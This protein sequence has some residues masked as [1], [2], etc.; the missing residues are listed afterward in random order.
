MKHL[1]LSLICTFG[2]LS[3]SAQSNVWRAVSESNIQLEQ[4]NK[5]SVRPSA[6][7]TFELDVNVLQT[8]LTQAPMEMTNEARSKAILVELPLADGR[9]ETFKIVNSPIAEPGYMAL[10]PEL[11][12]YS[13]ISVNHS[14]WTTRLVVTPSGFDA[15]ITTD[16][17]QVY[18]ET[19]AS[20]QTKYYIVYNTKD[21]DLTN[22][23][24][25]GPVTCGVHKQETIQDIIKEGQEVNSRGK[26]AEAVTIRKYRL[27]AATTGEFAALHGGTKAS[28]TAHLFKVMNKVN[29]VVGKEVAIRLSLIDK[30]DTL[31]FID[32]NKDPYPIGNQGGAMV[33]TNTG[34]LAKY[35]G[36][37]NYDFGHVFTGSCT[38]VGG[39]ASGLIC[40]QNG[41]GNG[42]SCDQ[43]SDAILLAVTIT[44]HE[45]G[46]Q[47]TAAHTMSDCEGV[48]PAQLG[49][50]IKIEPGSGTTIMSYDGG[51]GNQNLTG[52]YWKPNGYYHAG[53]LD[54]IISYT[55]TNVGNSCAQKLTSTTNMIP[56][57]NF[58]YKNGFNI[59]IS[60]PF[61][62][63]GTATDADNDVLTYAWDEFDRGV[64][65]SLGK[66]VTDAAI[67]R[68]Y[69]P[70]TDGNV[71][72]FPN[73]ASIV[74]NKKVV[75]ELLPTYDRK[76]TFRLIARDAKP[77]GGTAWKEVKFYA[78][79]TAGPFLVKFPNT[80]K[81]TL[82]ANKYTE[83]KWDVAKTNNTL[84]NCQKVSIALSTDGGYTYPTNLLL[85]T[86]NDGSEFVLIPDIASTKARVRVLAADN[87]FF[88][89]SNEDLQIVAATKPTYSLT[90]L[91][92]NPQVCLPGTANVNVNT[93][94]LAGFTKDVTFQVV[95]GLPNKAVATFTKNPL[96]A[97]EKTN[98]KL[99]LSKTDTTGFF[100]IVLRATSDGVV[101][102]RNI[103]IKVVA[104]DFSTMKLELPENGKAGVGVLPK[105]A[106][107]GSFNAARYE[108]QLS[109]S[110]TFETSTIVFDADKVVNTGYTPLATVVENTTYYW[111][112][113]AF[114]DCGA[115][116][117]T[118]PFAFHTVVLKCD[119][120][121]STLENNISASGTPTI[122]NVIPIPVD[123]TVNDL[124]V[125][126]NGSHE[127]F[128]SLIVTLISPKGTKVQLMKNACLP[129]SNVFNI[130][131]DDQ[132][133]IDTVSC[134]PTNTIAKPY[135]PLSTF[136]NEDIKGD[137]KL[138]VFDDTPQ[139][140]GK[141][142]LWK[143]RACGNVIVKP[144]VLERNNILKLAPK[145]GAYVN[146]FLLLAVDENNTAEQL[147]FTL[148]T[149]PQNG[150]LKF[151]QTTVLKVG[152]TFTQ[153]QITSA[154]LT[155]Y[156]TN[157]TAKSD[158]F[159]FI[160][161]DGEGGFIGTPKFVIDINSNNPSVLADKEVVLQGGVK[162]YPNPATDQLNVQLLQEH[163]GTISLS[164]FNID[165][166]LVRQKKMNGL[167]DILD[168]QDLATGFYMLKIQT[169]DGAY[170]Q[171]V[172][173]Q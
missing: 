54:Q 92:D 147:K 129:N 146:D 74:T 115:S 53:S 171:K 114:N 145:S 15:V 89:I 122:N 72:I 62:L 64:Q 58:D 21:L 37:L 42:V 150:I 162:C 46:H 105:F 161:E 169:Q 100:N 170:M 113:R 4:Y 43:S 56:E 164:L 86:D 87:I 1:L 108:I 121:E 132:A 5:R 112:I 130:L 24:L 50:S 140:G 83:I 151:N 47:M 133:P 66:P 98:L 65:A 158:Y 7:S 120:Y 143:M 125:T 78:S 22:I 127:E 14:N 88:D 94:A 134:P 128:N 90:Y 57:V 36:L 156:N 172:V 60:T 106:W 116:T 71:R 29:E 67:F 13:G 76:L 110:P 9:F 131:F 159:Y 142:K 2:V 69:T 34:T 28:T 52:V 119:T 33:G 96:P 104:N 44:A 18:I 55:R 173:K 38:D 167:A 107:K 103:Q 35:V 163:E 135:F 82:T 41:K 70:S 81:D 8:Q 166:Q 149:A 102:D 12:A 79:E 48:A 3:V 154:L 109:T 165:G 126:V 80:S 10:H 84:V 157:A 49:S 153:A 123:G 117:F 93:T 144:P 77:E 6:F 68:S 63:Q 61:I 75:S 152:D 19:Y 95:S 124:N 26:L 51:C 111:R 91:L 30:N 20:D 32:K 97:G 73:M 59:P 137:W 27:A 85:N 160:V 17:G 155:Y 139:G 118:E 138:S 45:M 25:S 31:V 99:D 16:E 141:L 40:T 23:P 39:V 168:L 136:N 11:G 148:V 101:T